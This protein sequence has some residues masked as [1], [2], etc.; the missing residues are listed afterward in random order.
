MLSLGGMW[1]SCTLHINL[2]QNKA[3]S[4]PNIIISLLS[5]KLWSL[6]YCSD[7]PLPT[8]ALLISWV[9]I[10]QCLYHGAH[11]CSSPSSRCVRGCI[12]GCVCN[13]PASARKLHWHEDGRWIRLD[14]CTRHDGWPLCILHWGHRWRCL[15]TDL[16]DG[17]SERKKE[18][19]RNQIATEERRN[20][21]SRRHVK[22]LS[23]FSN[24]ETATHTTKQAPNASENLCHVTFVPVQFYQQSESI[25]S[26]E[27]VATTER[28]STLG[29]CFP[30][31]LLV[32]CVY[33]R[34]KSGRI[35]C[36]CAELF[37]SSMYSRSRIY[38][39]IEF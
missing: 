10:S 7:C 14:S 33:A 35:C 21:L 30:I 11:L 12:P 3:A 24:D 9:N 15:H 19:M 6:H 31:F 5:S 4:P 34:R 39:C 38:A 16:R 27:I 23:K 32:V 26:G 20:S 8:C 29:W 22:R 2:C 36:P 25:W 18:K 28:P 1:S 13:E 37:L 17:S